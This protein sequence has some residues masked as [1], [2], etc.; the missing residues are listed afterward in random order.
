MSIRNPEKD[1]ILVL[2]EAGR[3]FQNPKTVNGKSTQT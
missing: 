2:T 3:K 1:E